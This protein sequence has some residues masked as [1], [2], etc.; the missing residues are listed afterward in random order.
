MTSHDLRF[1]TATIMY[2]DG[3]P[4]TALQYMLGHTTLQMTMHYL[5]LN[6]D[7]EEQRE[8]MLRSADITSLHKPA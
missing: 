4:L 8:F 2:R 1:S 5:K 3:I 6:C 7:L